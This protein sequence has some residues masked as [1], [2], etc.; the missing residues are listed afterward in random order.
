MNI[1]GDCDKRMLDLI[2]EF[3]AVAMKAIFR[4]IIILQSVMFLNPIG[5]Q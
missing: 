5:D 2:Y 1:W 3:G 4:V